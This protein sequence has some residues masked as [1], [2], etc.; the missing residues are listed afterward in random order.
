MGEFISESIASHEHDT[1]RE[2]LLLFHAEYCDPEREVIELVAGEVVR[3]PSFIFYGSTNNQI[4]MLR[5]GTNSNHEQLHWLGT[6]DLESGNV[7]RYDVTNTEVF[8]D[9]HHGRYGQ[10]MKTVIHEAKSQDNKGET[11]YLHLNGHFIEWHT[12]SVT[13]SVQSLPP[14]DC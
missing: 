2:K 9:P 1:G 4:I 7:T 10:F 3:Y 13:Y 11:A 6:F 5:A 14:P 8:E 12:E